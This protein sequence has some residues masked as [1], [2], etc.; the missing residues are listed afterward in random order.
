M[1]IIK[2]V[3]KIRRYLSFLF[4]NSKTA[5]GYTGVCWILSSALWIIYGHPEALSLYLSFFKILSV[6]GIIGDLANFKRFIKGDLTLRY[7]KCS[8][9]RRESFSAFILVIIFN[10][11]LATF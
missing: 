7:G 9:T 4:K 11:W 10:I 3:E 5:L 1:N 6:F 2:R 8:L